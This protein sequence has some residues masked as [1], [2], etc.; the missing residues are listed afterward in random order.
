[1]HRSSR[2]SIQ[3]SLNDRHSNQVC[4]FVCVRERVS[5]N[6]YENTESGGVSLQVMILQSRLMP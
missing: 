6:A 1:M 5:S 2:L 3:T 4:V